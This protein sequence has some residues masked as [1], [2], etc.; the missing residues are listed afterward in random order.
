MLLAAEGRGPLFLR[1]RR[2]E[3]QHFAALAADARFRRRLRSRRLVRSQRAADRM[4]DVFGVFVAHGRIQGQADGAFECLFRPREIAPPVP[5]MLGVEGVKVDGDEVHARAHALFRETL[6]ERLAID[7]GDLFVQIDD[8]QMPR[9]VDVIRR[10]RHADPGKLGEPLPEEGRQLL[11]PTIE[12]VELF[13]LDDPDRGRD[14][15]QV[16]LVAEL[17]DLVEPFAAEPVAL[18]PVRVSP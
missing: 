16:V 7:A 5:E 17:D 13:E 18:P 12:R 8:E 9:M 4:H 2:L 6:D 1:R 10:R 14:V 11:A 15:R 3:R